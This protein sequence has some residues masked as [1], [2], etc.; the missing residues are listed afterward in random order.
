MVNPIKLENEF[1]EIEIIPELGGRVNHLI[2]KK[3][4]FD[5]VWKNIHLETSKVDKTANYDQNWQGGWEELFPNDAIEQFSWGLGFDHGE[6]WSHS[7][8]K[9][10][11][12]T[13][14]IILNTDNLESGSFIQKKYSLFENRLRTDYKLKIN[15]EEIFLFKLHL[16]VPITENCKI[17]GE[18][19]SFTKVDEK[20]GNILNTSKHEYFLNPIKDS[21]LY[22]FAYIKSKSNTLVVQQGKNVLNLKYDDGFLNYLWLFQSQGGWNDHN[23][24][25]LE[26][27]SNG[28]KIFEDALMSGEYKKGPIEASTFYEV[29]I[30]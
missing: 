3:N 28:K 10:S 23:V 7:W 24:L 9:E 16:A 1:L 12:G 19:E 6:T 15:F 30:S 13:D 26:P 20:F 14:Y 29:T 25:V 11:E 21:N 27:S 8:V 2:D 18:F 5:W 22:D 4:K 17:I